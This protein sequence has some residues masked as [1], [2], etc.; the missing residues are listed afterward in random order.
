MRAEY[1]LEAY[2]SVRTQGLK[3]S[4]LKNAR[5]LRCGPRRKAFGSSWVLECLSLESLHCKAT[6]RNR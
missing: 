4:G 5:T 3:N 2:A 6:T 1:R